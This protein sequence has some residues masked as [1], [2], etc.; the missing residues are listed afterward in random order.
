MRINLASVFVTDQQHALD[1]YTTVLGF[2]L[3][4]NINMGEHAWLTVTA[5]GDTDGTQ[6]LLEPAAHPAVGPYRDALR[7][8]GIP[9]AQFAVDD[10]EAEHARLSDLGVEFSVPPT[11]VGPAMMAVFDDTC[12][13]Y[14]AMVAE[15]P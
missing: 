4:H 9:A 15:K 7:S 13:N 5:A 11:D 10:V 1:F 6:L 14:I 8:D 12:G 2:E 3:K